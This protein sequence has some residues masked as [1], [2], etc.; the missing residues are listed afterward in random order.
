MVRGYIHESWHT[1][2]D[3][4]L[5]KLFWERRRRT[6]RVVSSVHCWS[7]CFGLICCCGVLFLGCCKSGT[8]FWWI[9]STLSSNENFLPLIHPWWGETAITVEHCALKCRTSRFDT[10]LES[11]VGVRWS[12]LQKVVKCTLAPEKQGNSNTSFLFLSKKKSLH[13]FHRKILSSPRGCDHGESRC[14]S[15]CFQVQ[16]NKHQRL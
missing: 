8:E 14:G 6:F 3:L 10:L 7:W 12:K 2:V 15:C 11:T 13:V 9:K 16:T 5:W 1:T 4:S